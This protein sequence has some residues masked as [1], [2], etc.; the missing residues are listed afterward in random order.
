MK[1]LLRRRVIFVMGK[2]GVGKSVISGAIGMA[3]SDQGKRT[4]IAEMGGAEAMSTIFDRD[5]VGYRGGVLAG[6]LHAI[7]ITPAQAIEEYLVRVLRFRLLYEVVFRNRFIQPFVDGVLGLGDLISVGKVLDLEWQ[8]ADGSLGPD[9]RGPYLWDLVVV[10]APATGHGLNMLRAPQAVMDIARVGPMFTNSR[11]IRDLVADPER[12]ALLL[13]TLA[14]EMPITETID[15]ARRLRETVDVRI[16]GVVVNGTPP[17]LLGDGPARDGWEEVRSWG[18]ARG[19]HAASAVRDA[20]VAIRQRRRAEG[21][22]ARLREE[23]GLPL[24]EVP[25]LARRDLD[26]GALRAIGG[27]LRWT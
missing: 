8:R 17:D 3:A 10:D 14:E 11:Q 18:L 9:A 27:M 2:G 21:H 16:A 13:V 12:T 23:L 24:A 15:L 7:S 20:E 25:M 6:S 19:G 26:E 4:L 5:P 22:V 1:D